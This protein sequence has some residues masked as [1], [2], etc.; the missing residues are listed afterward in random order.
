MSYTSG[1]VGRELVGPIGLPIDGSLMR[2]YINDTQ[3]ALHNKKK[4]GEE[5]H[6]TKHEN[7]PYRGM[8][9]TLYVGKDAVFY[10]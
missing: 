2:V 8:C 4:M 1:G 5:C 9:C 6:L 10:M 7:V 3:L